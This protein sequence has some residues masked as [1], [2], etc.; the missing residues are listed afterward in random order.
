MQND[1]TEKG[2]MQND[3]IKS[4]FISP[5]SETESFCISSLSEER[6]LFFDCLEVFVHTLL[7]ILFYWSKA[8]LHVLFWLSCVVPL[9]YLWGASKKEDMQNIPAS[10][11]L[12][13][14]MMIEFRTGACV[15]LCDSPN[16]QSANPFLVEFQVCILS[17][18]SVFW[19]P[20]L[21]FGFQMSILSSESLFWVPSLYF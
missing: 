3:F 15:S 5:F 6:W 1:F 20:S 10:W 13:P 19:V 4:F 17:S 14:W 18:K 7:R 16:P 8:I 12:R 2:D 21:Y 11:Y 9:G